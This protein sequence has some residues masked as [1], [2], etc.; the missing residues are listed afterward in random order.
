MVEVGKSTVE[1]NKPIYLGVSIVDISKIL[2]Y[3]FHYEY[4][5]PMYGENV[6]LLM[7]D[8]DSLNYEIKT[9]D[10]EEDIKNDISEWFTIRVEYQ[11]E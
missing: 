1:L 7:T 9:P 2:M 10:F 6:K 3:K 5:K 4:I 8:T 11:L